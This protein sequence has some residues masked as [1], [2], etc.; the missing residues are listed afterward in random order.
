MCLG[1]E[2]KKCRFVWVQK[3][4]LSSCWPL[5]HISPIL[6]RTWGVAKRYKQTGGLAQ[7]IKKRSRGIRTQMHPHPDYKQALAY[8]FCLLIFGT[9][10]AFTAEK[11]L[12]LTPI[13]FI[14]TLQQPKRRMKGLFKIFMRL[15]QMLRTHAYGRQHLQQQ[16]EGL[17]YHTPP[18]NNRSN[19]KHDANTTA[20]LIPA[21]AE[22]PHPH[23]NNKQQQRAAEDSPGQPGEDAQ[24]TA[25]PR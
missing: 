24:G 13:S 17:P 16:G 10:P 2:K 14:M 23:S 7:Q 25:G 12:S 3:R 19:T 22:H 15:Q 4:Y 20:T 8:I 5:Q 9:P 11:R 1:S 6:G 18:N 21:T